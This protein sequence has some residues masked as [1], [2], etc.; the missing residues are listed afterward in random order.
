MEHSVEQG[1]RVVIHGKPYWVTKVTHDSIEFMAEPDSKGR[2]EGPPKS[3]FWPIFGC[4]VLAIV[5]IKLI[6]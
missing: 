3:S 2:L 4:I 6:F 1:D 5:L